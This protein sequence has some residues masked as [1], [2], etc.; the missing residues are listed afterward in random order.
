[1]NEDRKHSDED[2]ACAECYAYDVAQE[3]EAWDSFVDL[4]AAYSSALGSE[5]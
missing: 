5:R 3:Q 1:M 2:C 4:G